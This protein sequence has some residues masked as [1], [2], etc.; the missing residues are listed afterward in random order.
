MNLT[1]GQ[2]AGYDPF[3]S[4]RKYPVRA[5]DKEPLLD[6]VLEG[7]EREGCRILRNDTPD[8]APFRISFETPSGERLGVICYA[9][10]AN[11]RLT[12]NRPPDE[13]RF[14][15]K[16]G[17]DDK[18]HHA[19]WQDPFG[20]YTTLFVGINPEMGFFVG[21]DPE[22]H[23]PTRFFVSVEFK[24]IHAERILDRGW[25][26][27]ERERRSER[28]QE[29]VEVLVGGTQSRFLDFVRFERLAHGMDQGHR[30]LLAERILQGDLPT[31]RPVSSQP[32]TV[33]PSAGAVHEL[34]REFEMS[35]VEVL[36]LIAS[37]HRLKMAVRGWVA[38][39]HLVR[40][41]EKVRGVTECRRLDEEGGP[42]VKVL[43]ESQRPLTIEC[44]NVLRQTLA[45]GTIRLDFQRT[46]ASKSD[47]CTRYYKQDEFDVVAACLH[48]VTERWEFRYALSRSLDPHRVCAGRLSQTVRLDDR[49][50]GDAARIL[51][52]GGA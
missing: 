40:T 2:I 38:E 19:V 5:R 26:S 10:L 49:W 15:V 18:Q 33:A 17:P 43:F 13:H 45:D 44:K 28:I 35:Q 20:L 16:Y 6:F 29:P 25:H 51:R 42:D 34:A 24:D 47:P 41:L 30:Q 27:W 52:A 3:V 7:L 4:L 21:A 31:L 1:R 8:E 39:E 50:T 36:D 12:R 14:Q 46:R 23:N 9:F 32:P 37:A 22:I 11:R 48:A